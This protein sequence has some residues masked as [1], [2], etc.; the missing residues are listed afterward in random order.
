MY[1]IFIFLLAL[2]ILNLKFTP[3]WILEWTDR[4]YEETL[5]HPFIDGLQHL[6]MIP[7]IINIA[8]LQFALRFLIFYSIFQVLMNKPAVR[9]LFQNQDWDLDAFRQSFV[10]DRSTTSVSFIEKAEDSSFEHFMEFLKSVFGKIF[11]QTVF[12]YCK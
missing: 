10:M 1:R 5:S 2:A 6:L 7:V 8:V 12:F 4:L 9:S 11:E 3:E